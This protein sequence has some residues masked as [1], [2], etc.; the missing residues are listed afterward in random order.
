MADLTK[1]QGA[2]DNAEL[3][4]EN[5]VLKR[6]LRNL[7]SLLQRNKATLAARISVNTLL[8]SQKETMEKN[9]NLL[10]ENSPDIILLFDKAGR[11]THCTK[12][13]LAATDIASFDLIEGT[14][15]TDAF[16]K[17][18]SQEQ[19]DSLVNKYHQAIASRKTISVG[20]RLL[21]PFHESAHIYKIHITPM[22]D[23]AGDIDGAMMLFH[24]ISDLVKA[25]VEAEE[26]NKAKS[27]FLANMSHEIRTPLNA[28]IGMT[29][30][31]RK[32][33]D[34]QKKERTLSKIE[35]ASMN[36]LGTIGTILDMSKIESGHMEINEA[37]FDL[38]LMLSHAISMAAYG[39]DEKKL[40]LSYNVDPA[41]PTVLVG[42]RQRLL[43]VVMNLLSNAVKFTPEDGA[44]SL[45]A[46]LTD[47][48]DD[49]RQLRLTI[50]DTGIGI[51][52]EQMAS[53]FDPFMQA[54]SGLSRR[55]GGVGLGLAIS[56]RIVSMMGGCIEV[57]S[58]KGQGSRFIVSVWLKTP[59][60]DA[61]QNDPDDAG[62]DYAGAFNNRRIL[63]V[64]DTV[65]NKEV[66]IALLEPTGAHIEA[67]INGIEAVNLFEQ[68]AGKYDLILMDIHMPE[69]DG[70]E[71]ARRIRASSMP[72]G[73]TVPIVALTANTFKEDI[74]RCLA[75]GMNAHLGK[76]VMVD[77]MMDTI[78][79]CLNLT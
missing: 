40:T 76:P 57:E 75:A 20:E 60:E 18:V 29:H 27:E 30:L 26:A 34:L 33:D 77:K 10:L 45:H 42:D 9:L 2:P 66:V 12:T 78:N 11:F 52:K 32:T 5:R 35:T 48:R 1:D 22:L 19:L 21:F 51:S 64:E 61:A 16:R 38:E 55:F 17:F 31:F 79:K 7:E 39:L 58:E 43:Q 72:G 73:K 8:T 28:I 56:K 53:I 74:D 44:I 3:L 59:L 4:R 15:V 6:Q 25:K 47:A 54:E 65:I 37:P 50:S 70:Y 62:N 13:F 14:P 71:A 63:L 67:A 41:V 68:N 69:M 23:K 36:L 49:A 46:E 24:D